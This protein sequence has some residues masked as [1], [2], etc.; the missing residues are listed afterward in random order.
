MRKKLLVNSSCFLCLKINSGAE[1]VWLPCVV[2]V[3]PRAVI[4]L[5]EIN[6]FLGLI[7]SQRGHRTSGP[8]VETCEVKGGVY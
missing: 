6:R 1:A 4:D 7:G 5:G 2:M 3:T 8:W